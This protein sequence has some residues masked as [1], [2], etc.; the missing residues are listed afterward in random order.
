MTEGDATHSLNATASTINLLIPSKIGSIS[1]CSF[2]PCAPSQRPAPVPMAGT[3]MAH[4][5]GEGPAYFVVGDHFPERALAGQ[6]LTYCGFKIWRAPSG[7]SF[8]LR[9]MPATG[10]YT[11]DVNEGVL[12]RDPY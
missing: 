6:P 2:T 11:V 8:D 12:S 1:Q 9:H 7:L 3:P 5:V 4:V 10:F